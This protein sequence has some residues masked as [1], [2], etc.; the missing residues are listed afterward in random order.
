MEE[1]T[2][3][4]PPAGTGTSKSSKLN[5]EN[6]RGSTEEFRVKNASA[7]FPGAETEFRAE[8]ASA[9]FPGAETKRRA[10]NA[11]TDAPA[12]E[13]NRRQ[14]STAENH[15]GTEE[16]PG[17]GLIAA[18]SG[19]ASEPAANEG[20]RNPA[21]SGGK[22]SADEGAKSPVKSG[23]KTG[24][25]PA[26]FV[27]SPGEGS[28]AQSGEKPDSPAES[29]AAAADPG[30]SGQG[31]TERELENTLVRVRTDP[32]LKAKKARADSYREKIRRHQRRV[33]RRTVFFVISLMVVITGAVLLW[34][35]RGYTRAE[36]KRVA[37]LPME[38]GAGYENLGGKVVQYGS[39]GA[40]CIDQ[41]GNTLW[42]VSYEMQQPVTSVSGNVIAIANR[43]GYYVYV[44]N[45]KGLM[46]TIHTM[47]PIHSIA[48]AENGEVA[49]I[50]ND[51]KA[52]WVRLYTAQ[53][54]EIAYIIRTMEENGYP[55]AAA[56]SPDGKTLCLSTIQMS[57]AAVKSNISFYN[58]GKKGSKAS[59]HR[60]DSAD[61]IDEVIPR[62][63]YI[64]NSTCVGVSDR[65]LLFFRS[66]FF[67]K[68]DNSIVLFPEKE[69]LEGFF[70]SENFMGLLYSQTSGDSRYRLELYN[71]RAKK[72]GEIHFSMQYSDILIAGDKVYI[73]NGQ[74]CQIYTLGGRCLFDGSFG[75][76][77]RA[78][79][80]GA[81][82]S[83]LL[84][85]T[86][87]EVN[88]VRLH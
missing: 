19:P 68:S 73:Y 11:G 9:D 2:M 31:N 82:L 63:I 10:K 55:V 13:G 36:L 5:I 59:D 86:G 43:G 85:V 24:E 38:D 61:Y 69:N 22:T 46:G 70:S 77:I 72:A 14:E 80:P 65:R 51:N 74:Q 62:L 57:N 49:V 54:K 76:T 50:M 41:R 23:G 34:M 60:V 1:K 87:G 6:E 79:A 66:S 53:G 33:Y 71:K 21:K 37:V 8:N 32:A 3:Q 48:A 45:T 7:E 64:D 35:Y 40:R 84:V 83:D 4:S 47:L 58:F 18:D 67:R 78:L 15:P 20:K 16:E 26:V 30:T 81:R 56:V 44:M 12:A 27:D 42:S 29:A 75:R 28:A 39:S 17:K 25:K 88:L 52:T